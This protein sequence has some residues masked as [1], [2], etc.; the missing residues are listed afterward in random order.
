MLAFMFGAEN[1]EKMIGGLD[2]DD[3]ALLREDGVSV[4]R[5]G[6]RR[7]G[8]RDLA[9]LFA[10]DIDQ[11][12]PPPPGSFDLA[13]WVSNGKGGLRRNLEVLGLLAAQSLPPPPQGSFD[14]N[15]WEE[16]ENGDLRKK[17]AAVL[18]AQN[19][20]P[21]PRARLIQRSGRR[22]KRTATCGERVPG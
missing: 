18:S 14:A 15:E 13:Q 20:P 6:R 10:N 19:L 16:D 2:D 17:G 22:R 21:P 9:F 11:S 3:R 8:A 4:D 1:V 12:L 5:A 7:V